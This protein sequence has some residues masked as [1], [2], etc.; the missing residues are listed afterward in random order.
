MVFLLNSIAIS[1]KRIFASLV[2]IILFR[3]VYEFVRYRVMTGV[4][5][6][7]IAMY[8]CQY[9]RKFANTYYS[10]LKK[11]ALANS[12][13]KVKEFDAKNLDSIVLDYDEFE[14]MNDLDKE[15][16]KSILIGFKERSVD[17]CKNDLFDYIFSAATHSFLLSFV[18]MIGIEYVQNKYEY[19]VMTS[20]IYCA[21]VPFLICFG[22]SYR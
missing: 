10:A 22:S 19:G 14:K 21:S 4:M 12:K 13:S 17:C 1:I 5:G 2:N 15:P 18:T 6:F 16:L 11:R 3:Y 20:I 8:A 9:I 7:M